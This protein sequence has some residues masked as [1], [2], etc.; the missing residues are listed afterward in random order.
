MAEQNP[1][2]NNEYQ[3][4]TL[5]LGA[6]SYSRAGLARYT[7]LWNT[8]HASGTGHQTGEF[9]WFN[10]HQ[11]NGAC[12]ILEHI[13]LRRGYNNGSYY[14]W[15][16]APR[17]ALF[18]SSN[19]GNDACIHLRCQGR[20]SSGYDMGLY[21]TI[22]L[23]LYAPKASNGNVTPALRARGYSAPSDMSSSEFTN[24]GR[25]ASYVSYQSSAPPLTQNP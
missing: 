19:S 24:Q 11:N 6:A 20:R 2:G 18:H 25:N 4:F 5:D 17:M 7:I 10:H 9:R 1:Q 23:D 8:G 13:I 22:F 12:S 16:D 3:Y 21:V 15:N 14:G